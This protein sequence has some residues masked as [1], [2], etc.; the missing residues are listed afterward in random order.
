MRKVLS[1][2]PRWLPNMM[3]LRKVG[4][5]SMYRLSSEQVNAASVITAD[6]VRFMTWSFQEG[7]STVKAFGLVGY[8]C[9]GCGTGVREVSYCRARQNI[10]AIAGNRHR[11][12]S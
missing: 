6:G 9:A 12:K 11:G 3:T 10:K 2:N 5:I 7:V 1:V 8:N 4:R